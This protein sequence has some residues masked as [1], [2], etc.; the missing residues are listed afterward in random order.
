MPMKHIETIML[1]KGGKTDVGKYLDLVADA[2]M[3]V[4][5]F[6]SDK[7][8]SLLISNASDPWDKAPGVNTLTF[9]V[10]HPV[11]VFV[12]G[13]KVAPCVCCSKYSVEI[14]TCGFAVVTGE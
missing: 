9:S 5:R 6:L 3:I 1:K 10:D 7:N 8:E 4:G 13:K 12:N 2:D 11:Q 14:P